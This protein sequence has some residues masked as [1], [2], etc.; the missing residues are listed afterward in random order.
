M[1][2]PVK[3]KTDPDLTKIF[4]GESFLTLKLTLKELMNS[5]LDL[6]S[7]EELLYILMDY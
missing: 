7:L 4:Y 5:E 3:L 2:K 1:K 6:I